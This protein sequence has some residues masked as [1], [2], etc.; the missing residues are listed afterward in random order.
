[1]DVH[2]PSLRHELKVG[3]SVINTTSSPFTVRFENLTVEQQPAADE[4]SSF[5]FAP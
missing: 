4:E 1:M 3:V 5:E 2:R